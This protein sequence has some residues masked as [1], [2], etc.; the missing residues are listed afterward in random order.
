MSLLTIAGGVSA[1]SAPDT[2]NLIDIGPFFDRFDHFVPGTKLSILA[3]TD[4]TVQAIVKDVQSRKWITLDRP[5]VAQ[6][7][8]VLIAKAIPNVDATLK[9][10]IVGTPV[11]PEE[12]LALRKLYFS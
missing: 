7:I 9:A 4:A 8:D 12:N 5:D 3:S 6:A 1:P 2:S 11:Q 10:H